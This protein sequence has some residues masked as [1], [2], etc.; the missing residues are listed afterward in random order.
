MC[1]D[2]EEEVSNS[3]EVNAYGFLRIHNRYLI[4]MRRICKVHGFKN[5]I[6]PEIEMIGDVCLPVSRKYLSNVKNV[7]VDWFHRND[8]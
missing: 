3:R 7:F 5:K 2:G 1:Y 6:S 4:N 8:T